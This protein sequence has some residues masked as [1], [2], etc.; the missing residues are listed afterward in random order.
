LYPSR[1]ED[2]DRHDVESWLSSIGFGR[3]A[4]SFAKDYSGIGVDGDRLVYLGT[5][6]QL[7]HI[8]YQLE[9]IGVDNRSDQLILGSSIIDLVAAEEVTPD[10]LAS[11][12]EKVPSENRD[13]E[14][15]GA[16]KH[17]SSNGSNSNSNSSNGSNSSS[18]NS[19]HNDD[20]ALGGGE[21]RNFDI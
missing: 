11:L 18:H 5:E 14:K 9:L 13:D 1:L 2:W 17:E 16:C 6:D 3:Y 20:S 10:L 12:E 19:S 8:E 21:I 7:D 15:H 4:A